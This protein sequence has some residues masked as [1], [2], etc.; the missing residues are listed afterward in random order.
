MSPSP[1]ALA[2]VVSRRSIER[3]WAALRACPQRDLRI[4]DLDIAVTWDEMDHTGYEGLRL[5]V[6]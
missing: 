2:A 5:S 6:R 1:Y 3:P 4:S